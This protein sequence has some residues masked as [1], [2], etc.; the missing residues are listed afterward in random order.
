MGASLPA[1]YVCAAT[2]WR[3]CSATRP[4]RQGLRAHALPAPGR[5]ALVTLTPGL[6]GNPMSTQATPDKPRPQDGEAQR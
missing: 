3:W 2:K 4:P 5:P 1:V 6:A